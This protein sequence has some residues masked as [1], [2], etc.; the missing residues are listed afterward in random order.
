[1]LLHPV[2]TISDLQALSPRA[3]GGGVIRNLFHDKAILSW[4]AH[5]LTRVTLS[6]VEV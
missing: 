3:I 1:M 2:S 6:F 4:F 5:V